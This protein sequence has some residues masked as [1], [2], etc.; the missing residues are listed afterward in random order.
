VSFKDHIPPTLHNAA[1]TIIATVVIAVAGASYFWLRHMGSVAV[2]VWLLVLISVAILG[3]FTWVILRYRRRIRQL[4]A[5]RDR[6]QGKVEKHQ[7]ASER[8]R[9]PRRGWMSGFR[10]L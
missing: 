5:E 2:P 9:Y 3:V 7:D 1:G 4:T 6:L 10:S 8:Y